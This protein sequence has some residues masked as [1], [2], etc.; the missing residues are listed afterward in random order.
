MVDYK[1]TANTKIQNNKQMRIQPVG[2]KM[3]VHVLEQLDHKT[4]SGLTIVESELSTGEIIELSDELK[5]A[6]EVGEKVLFPK[7]N[8]IAKIYKNKPCKWLNAST[9]IWG[10]VTDNE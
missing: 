5:G 10:K 1:K 8:G 4:E 6:Y 2:N 7:N 3:I 9:E